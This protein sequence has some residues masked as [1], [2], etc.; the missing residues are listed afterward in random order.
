MHIDQNSIYNPNIEW[1]TIRLY[2][3]NRKRRIKSEHKW[4]K[5]EAKCWIWERAC[6]R[7]RVRTLTRIK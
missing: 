5:K 7:L 4:K 2:E 6:K 1:C 3:S